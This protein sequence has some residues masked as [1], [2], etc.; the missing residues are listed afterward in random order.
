MLLCDSAQAIGGKLYI[1]GGGWTH[2]LANVP[3]QMALAVRIRV[4]WDQANEPLD[5]RLHLITAEGE[6]VD[7]GQGPVEATTRIEVGRPP[8]LRRGSPLVSVSSLN[9][10]PLVLPA[11]S[12]VWELEIVNTEY[13]REPFEVL[14]QPLTMGG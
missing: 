12:Y 3:V 9:V 10:G 4:P 8:G 1:L 2:I 14:A 5:M 13:A 6:A 11:G 7:V